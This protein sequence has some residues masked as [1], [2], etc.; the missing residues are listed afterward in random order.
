MLIKAEFLNRWAEV[1]SFDFRKLLEDN[2]NLSLPM[3]TLVD[4]TPV[5][6]AF[7]YSCL[8]NNKV[9]VSQRHFW[10][11]S[12]HRFMLC[13]TSYNVNI[14]NGSV[15]E[16]TYLEAMFSVAELLFKSNL[17]A[18]EKVICKNYLSLFSDESLKKLYFSENKPL[19][20]WMK[21]KE[22]DV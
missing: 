2:Q 13:K 19:T 10:S 17:S 3:I 11:L 8:P 9:V 15:D 16:K 12:E 18:E 22:L 6:F 14:Q 5:I 1:S 4:N 20:R 7:V 21:S